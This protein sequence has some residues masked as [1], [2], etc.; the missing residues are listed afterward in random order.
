MRIKDLSKCQAEGEKLF[1]Q[2][3]LS[4]LEAKPLESG[5]LKDDFLRWLS[6]SYPTDFRIYA[7]RLGVSEN[8]IRD[9][10]KGKGM[11]MFNI[12]YLIKSFRGG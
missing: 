4:D 7:S 10:L 8:E 6:R 11:D 2:S 9:F 12:Y 1:G 5:R 3:G